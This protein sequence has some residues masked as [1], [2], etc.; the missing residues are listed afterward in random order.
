VTDHDFKTLDDKEFES[1]CADPLGDMLGKR[2]ERFKA[3]RDGGVDGRYFSSNGKG[4]EGPYVT[5]RCAK[6]RCLRDF[7]GMTRW[8][9]PRALHFRSPDHL[10]IE[11]TRWL[12]DFCVIQ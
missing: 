3:G 2:F 10:A 7:C 5:T 1:L 11:K 4:L 8:L 12:R 6:S 9:T